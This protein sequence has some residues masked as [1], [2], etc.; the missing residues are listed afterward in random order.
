MRFIDLVDDASAH[1]TNRVFLY[2]VS[3]SR[4]VSV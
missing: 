1:L 4:P 3:T 2:F